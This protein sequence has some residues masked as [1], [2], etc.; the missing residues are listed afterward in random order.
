MIKLL[1]T[2][3]G[4]AF[5]GSVLAAAPTEAGGTAATPKKVQTTRMASCNKQATGKKG[6]ER[7]AF[8]K[9]CLKG[10]TNATAEPQ[11]QADKTRPALQSPK[12]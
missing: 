1:V 3:A 11:T 8:M 4:L 7:K 12:P 5:T 2:L 10:T 6:A 9:T